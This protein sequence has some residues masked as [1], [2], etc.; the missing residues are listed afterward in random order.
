MV[1]RQLMREA[2]SRPGLADAGGIGTSAAERK[3]A[4]AARVGRR[5]MARSWEG[6]ASGALAGKNDTGGFSLPVAEVWEKLNVMR[7]F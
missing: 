7:R 4:R 1:V 5:A 6:R 2:Y 3:S